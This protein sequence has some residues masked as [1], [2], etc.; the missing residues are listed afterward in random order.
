MKLLAGKRILVTG[1][2]TGIG[3]GIAIT[4]AAEGATV[5]FSYHASRKGADETLKQIQAGG[6]QA[7]AFSADLSKSGEG[8]RLVQRA[9]SA[10]QGLDG[11]VCNAGP[12]YPK[13]FQEITEEDWDL[14]QNIHLKSAFFTAQA[15]VNHLPSPGGRLVFI[16]SVHGRASM[17]LFSPYAAAKGGLDALT[18]QLAI[19]LGPKQITVNCVAPGVV[20]VESYFKDKSYTRDAAALQVPLG[21]VGFPADIA[22]TVAFLLSHHAAFTTGQTHY[23][24]GG[25]TAR[26]AFHAL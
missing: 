13:P 4:L 19:E 12:T 5:C 11:L 21:R 9:A 7:M 16:G 22:P 3:Q 20:E 6:N 14:T 26:L 18:R 17:P 15:A 2:G 1:G 8:A 23:L 10:M 24:D 25:Q